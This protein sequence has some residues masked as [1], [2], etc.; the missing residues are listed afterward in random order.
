MK[1]KKKKKPKFLRPNYGRSS[2]KRIKKNWRRQRGIDNK[3]RVKKAHM[4]KSPSIGYGQAKAIRFLHPKGK[5]EILVRNLSELAEVKDCLVRI[6]ASIGKKLRIKLMEEAA[7]RKLIVLNPKK[8]EEKEKI[9]ASGKKEDAGANEKKI[10]K[11]EASGKKEDA[12]AKK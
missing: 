1:I 7:K 10:E 5:K 8:F 9:E 2:R 3:K 12:G 4:G 6:S 11:N